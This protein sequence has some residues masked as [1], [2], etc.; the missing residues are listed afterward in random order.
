MTNHPNRSKKAMAHEHKIAKIEMLI[1][2]SGYNDKHGYVYGYR[3]TCE[4]GQSRIQQYRTAAA[5]EAAHAHLKNAAEIGE[6]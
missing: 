1:E 2:Y 4:C 3:E 5:A 6:G